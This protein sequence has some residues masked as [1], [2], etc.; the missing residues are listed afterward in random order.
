M[1]VGT[2]G[3]GFITAEILFFVLSG[4]EFYSIAGKHIRLCLVVYLHRNKVYFF[5]SLWI[6]FCGLSTAEDC[7]CSL[8]HL[9]I[10]EINFVTVQINH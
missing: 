9:Y 5:Q 8:L 3:V 4:Q 6:K 10:E 1:S 7:K 2:A